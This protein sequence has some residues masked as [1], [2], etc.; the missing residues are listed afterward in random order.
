MENHLLGKSEITYCELL[1]V[2]TKK[3]SICLFKRFFFI[4]A[5]NIS[6]PDF[7]IV[8]ASLDLWQIVHYIVSC[9]SLF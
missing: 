5:R 4:C 8:V 1:K 6:S 2:C 3:C 9:L 7:S